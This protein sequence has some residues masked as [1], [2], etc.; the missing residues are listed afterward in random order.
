[1]SL[2][3]NRSCVGLACNVFN[4]LWCRTDGK[5]LGRIVFQLFSDVTPRTAEN[6]RS[7]CT[8]ERG[9]ILHYKG[10]KLHRIIKDFMIQ[11]WILL[12]RCA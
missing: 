10:V 4:N 5:P 6:F 11:V 12:G 1:M 9:G 8:G 2:W 7:L 3:A